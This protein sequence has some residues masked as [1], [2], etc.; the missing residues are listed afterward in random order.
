MKKSR[1]CIAIARLSNGKIIMGGDRRVSEDWGFAYKCPNPKVR[2]SWNGIL[3]GASG[4]SGLCKFIVD[5]FEPPKIETDDIDTYM[6]WNYLPALN[7]LLKSIPGYKD[8]H[9]L[10][11]ITEDE[12]CRAIVVVSD[13]AYTVEILSNSDS[14]LGKIII[15]DA[16]LPYAI[17]CGASSAIPVLLDEFNQKGYNTK[18]GLT[19][20][21]AIAAELSPGCDANIDLLVG[22]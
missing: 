18:A 20:A 4:D 10:L 17:G 22:D 19:K 16:P 5:I 6:Y 3:T 12:Y 13:K 7:K 8:A 21:M 9:N 11:K 14:E 15:D 2:K 1:T